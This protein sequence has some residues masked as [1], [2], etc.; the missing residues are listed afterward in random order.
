MIFFHTQLLSFN[1]SISNLIPALTRFIPGVDSKKY[2]TFPF[3]FL[4]SFFNSLIP[5]MSPIRLALYGPMLDPFSL[6]SWIDT[7]PRI[8]FYE[9]LPS[10]RV[11]MLT[12]YIASKLSWDTMNL[13]EMS[14]SLV[15]F[16]QLVA[17][18]FP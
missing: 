3:F 5:G 4:D 1:I 2:L 7:R 14:R 13:S 15:N 16:F 9:Y 18:N 11:M 8:V 6:F 17:T 12:S 10:W